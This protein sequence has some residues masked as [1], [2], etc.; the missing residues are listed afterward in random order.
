MPSVLNVNGA[1][2]VVHVP[3]F[4]LYFVYAM[5]EPDVESVR[6]IDTVTS[7]V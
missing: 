2:Y 4:T 6:E 5:P 7:V 3:P 1:V